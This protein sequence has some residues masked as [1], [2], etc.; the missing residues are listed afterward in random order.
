MKDKNI[1]TLISK[2]ARINIEIWHEEDRARS[3]DDYKVAKAKR[4]ID[5]LN[6]KRNDIIEEIDQIIVDLH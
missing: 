1:G 5:M 3:S 6:Q 4:N 2:L